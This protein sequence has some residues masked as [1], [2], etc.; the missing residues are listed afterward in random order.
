MTRIAATLAFAML[1]ASV[2]AAP[3][4]DFVAKLDAQRE[5]LE[6]RGCAGQA[7]ERVHLRAGSGAD[8]H[9]VNV[10]RADGS[11]AEPVD[12][13]VSM[14]DWHAGECYRATIDLR[15][16]GSADRWGLGRAQDRWYRLAPALWFWRPRQVD[17]DSSIRF[18]L[19]PGWAA[20]VPWMPTSESGRHRLGATPRDWPA[21]TAFGRFEEHLL[22]L[23]GGRLRVSLLPL[24]DAA[25]QSEIRDWF[26]GNASMLLANDGR[27]PLPDAQVLIVP[28]PGVGSPVPWGQVSRGGGA[29]VT[30]FV[31]AAAGRA[32]WQAD[33]TLAHELA[34]LQ[35]PF[36]GDRGRWLAEG[37]GS[38]YQN[39]W[40]ARRGD[41]SGDEAWRRLDAGF[42]RGRAVGT[43]PP[44]AEL[45]RGRGATMRVYWSGAAYW[46]ESDLALRAHGS[47]LDAVLAAFR[48]AHLPSARAWD[49]REF[50]AALDRT[51]PAA[52]MLAR[53]HRYAALRDFPD[54]GDAYD[55]LGLI[56]GAL[57]DGKFD[58]HPVRD[59]IMRSA[60]RM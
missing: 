9:L 28:L 3:R 30:L 32:G 34:H 58:A 44:L 1:A 11:E 45:T 25:V 51:A 56:P 40:R 53:Y 21:Q 26:A 60:P 2:G 42:A 17:P 37:L 23:P 19:P 38:Y 50:I 10:L 13:S 46:L 41:F 18:E 14:R 39:V 15:S 36:L 35:H 47:S 52:Q 54:L 55:R 48:D 16:A 57:P 20:S 5:R 7:I 22:A 27:L 8:A 43:G 59:A 49:P 33:W 12:G 29:A 4:W 24:V 6:L 31:G